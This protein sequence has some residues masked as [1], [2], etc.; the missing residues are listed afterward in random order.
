MTFI[1]QRSVLRDTLLDT[2]W[3]RQVSCP[4]NAGCGLQ[5]STASLIP[6]GF[7]QRLQSYLILIKTIKTSEKSGV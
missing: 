7:Q 4:C 6:V 1:R 2:N 3:F 5:K